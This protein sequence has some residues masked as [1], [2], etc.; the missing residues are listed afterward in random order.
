[1]REN[2][3]HMINNEIRQ[4]Q[5]SFLRGAKHLLSLLHGTKNN[6]YLKNSS[7]GLID[8]NKQKM[9]RIKIR[10]LELKKS[11]LFLFSL[12]EKPSQSY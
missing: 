5:L 3:N 9:H 11:E 1:M 2:G 10:A 6:L 8:F 4:N 7:T 12:W